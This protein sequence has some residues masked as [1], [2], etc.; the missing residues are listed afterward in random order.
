M[1]PKN[2]LHNEK[3]KIKKRIFAENRQPWYMTPQPPQIRF[4]PYEFIVPFFPV[5]T[6]PDEPAPPYRQMGP[7]AR[8][9]THTQKKKRDLSIW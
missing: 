1:M 4:A 5:N 8:T 9:A 2:E 3:G 7:Q 6:L